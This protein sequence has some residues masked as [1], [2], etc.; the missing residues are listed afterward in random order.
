ML[1]TF[2]KTYKSNAATLH[3]V[4]DRHELQLQYIIAFKCDNFYSFIEMLN[5]QCNIDILG[6]KRPYFKP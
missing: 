2:L 6:L 4:L 3:F 5:Y 1:Q